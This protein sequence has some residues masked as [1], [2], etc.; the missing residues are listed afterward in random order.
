MI[1]LSSRS[2]KTSKKFKTSSKEARMKRRKEIKIRD[3]QSAFR[4]NGVIKGSLELYTPRLSKRPEEKSYHLT[5]M[6]CIF[7][8]HPPPLVVPDVGDILIFSASLQDTVPDLQIIVGS[9]P[10]S[11]SDFELT[12]VYQQ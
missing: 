10:P 7:N 5:F 3:Q 8:D 2:Y 4:C 1:E 9:K 11:L 6:K 12:Q